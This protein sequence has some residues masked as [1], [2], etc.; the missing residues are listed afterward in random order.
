MTTYIPNN[1]RALRKTAGLRQ[2]DVVSI[3]GLK[4]IDQV[5]RWENGL[6]YP[7]VPILFRLARLYNVQPTEVYDEPYRSVYGEPVS[8]LSRYA[9]K[10]PATSPDAVFE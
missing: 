6:A 2:Q 9:S 5:S 10:H 4:G 7:S 1:L 8:A 3:L